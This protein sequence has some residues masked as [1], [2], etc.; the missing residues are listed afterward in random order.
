MS[1]AT[2]LI[3]QA[4]KAD[5]EAQR[6]VTKAAWAGAYTHIFTPQEID[7]IFSEKL[8]IEADWHK[9]RKERIGF[10]VAELGGEAV[11][12]AGYALLHDGDGEVTSL[13]VH[14]KQQ[15]TGLGER[16]WLRCAAALRERGCRRMMVWTLERTEAVRFYKHMGCELVAWGEFR[17]GEHVEA[18]RG[19]SLDL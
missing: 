6:A 12:T 13:Y 5:G 10:F 19:Y 1:K 11:G 9:F 17:A 18:A 14:P 2:I 8:K 7:A 15:G 4:T 16:L 3:R